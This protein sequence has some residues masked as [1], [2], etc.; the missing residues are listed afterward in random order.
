MF[1][2][3][4]LVGQSH[5]QLIGS[6]RQLLEEESFGKVATSAYDGQSNQVYLEKLFGITKPIFDAISTI[7]RLTA[8]SYVSTECSRQKSS[9]RTHVQFV[10]QAR[11]MHCNVL[12]FII[13]AHFTLP[14]SY[15]TSAPF[16]IA[17][18]QKSVLSWSRGFIILKQSLRSNPLQI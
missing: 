11:P 12:L 3:L 1:R 14:V 6:Y 15:I 8:E 10:F 7:N 13:R 16:S 9:C 4:E 5:D 18:S 2:C 17:L